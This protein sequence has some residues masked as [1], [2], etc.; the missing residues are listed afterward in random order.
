MRILGLFSLSSE[1][2]F[3]YTRKSLVTDFPIEDK[4]Q[5]YE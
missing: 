1:L 4:S 5:S 2:V 3:I